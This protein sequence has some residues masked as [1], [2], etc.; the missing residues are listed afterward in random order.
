M[1]GSDGVVHAP[2]AAVEAWLTEIFAGAG[3]PPDE[4]RQVAENL[5]LAD[6]SGHPSHG[7]VRTARY[8]EWVEQGRMIPAAK[9]E[10]LSRSGALLLMDA[11]Y[12]FGQVAGAKAVDAAADVA[13]AEGVCLLGLRRSGHLGRI[14]AWAERLCARGLWS[15]HWVSVPGSRLVAPF[16]ATERRLG[17]NPICVGVPQAGG[18]FVLDF[19]TSRVA[20]GKVLVALK[21][22]KALP[23]DAMVDPDG[24]DSD[25][26]A[27]LYGETASR[28]APDPRAGPGALQPMGDHKGSG[29]ALACELLAGALIGSGTNA[30][31]E[32][33]FCN[34]MLSIVLDPKRFGDPEGIAAEAAA[35]LEAVRSAAPRDAAKPVL[36]PGEPERAGREAAARDGV[37]LSA[38]LRASL[39]EASAKTGVAVPDA[40]R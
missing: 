24:A 39:A 29:L 5:V 16:G 20:E 2:Q 13:E 12:S 34:G 18:D 38:G 35:F 17:T 9:M 14:G 22:G 33:R 27:T 1:D 23:P 26:P 19:A 3:C 30:D 36:T 32:A 7:I 10:T 40:M 28:A 6:L 8:V 31:P 37:P 4:A 15:I 21:S 11:H 25:R